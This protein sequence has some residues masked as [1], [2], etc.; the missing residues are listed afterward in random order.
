MKTTLIFIAWFVCFTL[1]LDFAFG[2]MSESST[3]ANIVGC[4]VLG[5][6]AAYSIETKCFTQFKKNKNEDNQEN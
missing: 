4:F 2:L 6:S 5:A 3:V 1:A